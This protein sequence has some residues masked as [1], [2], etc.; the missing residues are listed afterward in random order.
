[1]PSVAELEADIATV[2]AK[3][4]VIKIG[5]F[6]DDAANITIDGK[7]AGWLERVKGER[8]KSASSRARVSYV[9]GYSIMLTDD[10]LDAQLRASE[11]DVASKGEAIAAIRAALGRL[12]GM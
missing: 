8:F 3:R 1:M 7:V 11:S 2:L 4:H 10:A 5:R 9:E 6:E 12:K